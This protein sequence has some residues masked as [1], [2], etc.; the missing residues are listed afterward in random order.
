MGIVRFFL[1][2]DSFIAHRSFS[3][4]RT[5]SSRSVRLKF[6]KERQSSSVRFVHQQMNDLNERSFFFASERS[7]RAKKFWKWTF[8]TARSKVPFKTFIRSVQ[9]WSFLERRLSY[10]NERTNERR[11]PP[12]WMERHERASCTLVPFPPFLSMKAFP[13][14]FAKVK[15]RTKPPQEWNAPFVRSFAP[16]SSVPFHESRS[17][18]VLSA[19]GT[20]RT[21]K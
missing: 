13:G 21:L 2:N 1:K 9:R 11:E 7:E 3:K 17:W 5:Q 8:W 15:E 18:N 6:S 20:K 4:E 14:T 16:R 19:K 12:P 10:R